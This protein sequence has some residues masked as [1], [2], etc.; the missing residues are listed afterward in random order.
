M[1]RNRE[2]DLQCLLELLAATVNNEAAPE[3]Y[4]EPNWSMVYKLADYHNVANVVYGMILG[5]E[6]KRLSR[7]R[8]HFEY[9]F[10]DCAVKYEKSRDLEKVIIR[11][12][13][14]EK[15]HCLE[16]E[17]SILRG[18]YVKKEQHY[19]MPLNFLVEPKRT[20][21]ITD[22]M[23][24]IGFELKTE[25]N[26]HPVP[27]GL[28]FRRKD[29]ITIVFYEK[30]S[31]SSRRAR[32]YFALSPKPFPR[33]KG[34][35]Y[36]HAQDRDDFYIYYLS[37]LAEKYATGAVEIRDLLDLWHYYQLSYEKMDWN[38]VSKELKYL[39][40]EHFADLLIKLAAT[41][42][43]NYQGFDEDSAMLLDMER[44]VISKGA[45]AR[46]ENE[47]L[48]PLV[49]VQADVYERDLKKEERKKARALL[50][51]DR[52]YMETIY[53]I[54]SKG[55][56]LLPFCWAAR[57]ISRQFR[58]IRNKIKDIFKTLAEKLKR[59]NKDED[60]ANSKENENNT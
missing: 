12:L 28:W 58:K 49:K 10:R 30:I 26:Q 34:C 16:L 17:E 37:V 8:G 4:R 22:A 27:E 31:F 20:N 1:S 38:V 32:K 60:P 33:K 15:V 44:Y 14:K 35:K 51:P 40:L 54:L 9:R 56:I 18:C 13:E 59:K 25:H 57:L 42:F 39:G 24:R 47:D 41:W 48:L 2:Y 7:W 11:E 3:W 6:G 5:M 46:D 43:G 53:P 55:G 45:E 36:V 19:P 21:Q 23:K 52:S 50:F 29:G